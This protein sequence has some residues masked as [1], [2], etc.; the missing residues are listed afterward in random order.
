LSDSER[1]YIKQPL[2]IDDTFLIKW[3]QGNFEDIGFINEVKLRKLDTRG[4]IDQLSDDVRNLNSGKSLYGQRDQVLKLWRNLVENAIVYLKSED[5][6]ELYRDDESYGV[7]ELYEFFETLSDFESLLYGARPGYREHISHMFSVF[8]L[9]ECL[10]RE[11]F[12]FRKIDV[13]DAALPEGQKILENEKEAMWCIMS[14]THDLGIALQDIRD[15]NPKARAML[16]KFGI[17]DMQQLSYSFPRQP[18]HDFM[19]QL[20]SST[21]DIVD[22]QDVTTKKGESFTTHIQPKYFLKFAEAFERIDHGLVSCLVLMKNLVYFLETDL[23]LEPN[24]PFPRREDAKQFLIRCNILRSIASHSCENIYYLTLPQFPFLLTIF[25][26]MHEWGRPRFAELFGPRALDTTVILEDLSE[27]AIHYRVQFPSGDLPLSEDEKKRMGREVAQF[28]EKKC[29]KIRKILRSAVGG[30]ER[31][32]K[33]TFEV[34]R[35]IGAV[36]INYKVIH[37]TPQD[38]KILKDDR[39]INWLELLAEAQ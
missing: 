5:T 39:E 30:E 6:R 9:G 2:T 27:G 38:V 16:K 35:K 8:L 12:G 1:T 15:V 13:G 24:R 34:S 22:T 18:L 26:E 33:L 7:E 37:S 21:L 36:L 23:I 28:F 4:R 3:L 14:L 19:L 20:I 17:M 31:K 25:D 10:I 32:L 29:S 11:T